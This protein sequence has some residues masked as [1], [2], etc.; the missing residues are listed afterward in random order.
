MEKVINSYECLFIVDVT[1]G[2]EACDATVNKFLSM[3]EA[4]AEVVDVAKW[5]KRRLA[6]PINDMPEGYYVVATFK[7]EPAFPA[8]LERVFN[9]D[10]TIMR[11]MIIRLEYDAA[12][13]KAEKAA[14]AAAEAVAEPVVEAAVEEAAPADAE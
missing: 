2:D 12:E 5:G 11:S 4:N 8:E 6:Y 10:E 3:I 7:T 13:K 1:K 14:K 9:I